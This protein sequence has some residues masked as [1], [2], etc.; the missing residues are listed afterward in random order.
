MSQKATGR[1][2]RRYPRIKLSHPRQCHNLS[3]GGFY[4][5]TERPRRLGTLVDFELKLDDDKNPIRGRGRVVRIIHLAGAVGADPPGM[6]V[7]FVELSRE[8]RERIRAVVNQTQP[9]PSPA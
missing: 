1:E 3:E 7:E 2:R 6:A 4:M 8:D 5:L 9:R